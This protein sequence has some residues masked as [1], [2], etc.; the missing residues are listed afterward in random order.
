[1][2]QPQQADTSHKQKL[3][4][5]NNGLNLMNPTHQETLVRSSHVSP[6]IWESEIKNKQLREGVDKCEICLY[7]VSMGQQKLCT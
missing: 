5:S 7:K 3:T 2:A 4:Y 6:R 1:M